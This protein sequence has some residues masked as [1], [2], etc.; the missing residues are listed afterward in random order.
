MSTAN[1]TTNP[2]M[3]P[4]IPISNSAVRERILERITITAPM[5]PIRVGMG[6]K[7]G[8]VA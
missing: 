5:V 4:A 1:A 6:I 2:A 3:G 8:S 7:N